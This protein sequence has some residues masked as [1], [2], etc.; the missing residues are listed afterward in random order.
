MSQ[1][2][3]LITDEELKDMILDFF[4]FGYSA[5]SGAAFVFGCFDSRY[6]LTLKVG[7]L[8]LPTYLLGYWVTKLV[9]VKIKLRGA[10]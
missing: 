2:V 8:I 5:A 1:F 9:N 10:K 7:H 3:I 6:K 4:I